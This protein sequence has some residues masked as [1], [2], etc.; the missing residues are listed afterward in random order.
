RVH[1]ARAAHPAEAL[2]AEA[3]AEQRRLRLR[4]RAGAD[5]DVLR[6]VR[7]SR[8][9]RDD[10][11]VERQL[12][13]LLPARLVVLVDDRL[14]AGRLRQQ[15]EEVVGERVVVV[16]QQRLHTRYF[17]STLPNGLLGISPRSSTCCGTL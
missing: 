4:D 16:D 12:T 10:D 13:Q 5:P 7:S 3:D 1:D 14:V 15:L 11:V 2:V 17:R 9:G 6:A 8:T